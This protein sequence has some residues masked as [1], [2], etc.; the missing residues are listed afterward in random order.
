MIQQCGKGIVYG[1]CDCV[2]AIAVTIECLLFIY[3]SS[4]LILLMVDRIGYMKGS[5]YGIG[6]MV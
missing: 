2:K 1:L 3:S 4:W 5:Y 6:K